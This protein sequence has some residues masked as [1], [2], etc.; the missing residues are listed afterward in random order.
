MDLIFLRVRLEPEDGHSSASRVIDFALSLSLSL[1]LHWSEAHNQLLPG[2]GGGCVGLSIY[3]WRVFFW[4]VLRVHG[5]RRGMGSPDRSTVRECDSQQL[6]RS[7]F[8]LRPFFLPFFNVCARVDLQILEVTMAATRYTSPDT[9]SLPF[10]SI[11]LLFFLFSGGGCLS[12]WFHI[13]QWHNDPRSF[14]CT[15]RVRRRWPGSHQVPH[16]PTL[17]TRLQWRKT[18]LK[19]QLSNRKIASKRL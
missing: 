5:R 18:R 12:G 11:S 7:R 2:G 3:F 6:S 9:S 19:N 10:D 14:R 17:P 16:A 4:W 15:V 13:H 8:L 1:E